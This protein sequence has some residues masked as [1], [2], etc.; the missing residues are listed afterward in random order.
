MTGITSANYF[1]EVASVNF[2]ALPAPLQKGHD[3]VVRATDGGRSW[4]MFNTSESIR[5][6]SELYFQQLTT[7]LAAQTKL[8]TAKPVKSKAVKSKKASSGKAKPPR[9]EKAPAKEKKVSTSSQLKHIHEDVKIIKRY[10]GLHNRV[11]T[12]N[13]ILN[14]IKALQKAIVQGFIT[15]DAKHASEIRYIQDKLVSLY[16]RMKEEQLILINDEDL[17]RLI[18]IAG[19]E[20]VFVSVGII[21]RFIGM[22][23][24]AVD[25]KRTGNL[26]KFIENGQ[27]KNKLNDDP[28]E[29]KVADI[30]KLLKKHNS[31]KQIKVAQAELNG[32]KKIVKTCGC[33][34]SVPDMKFHNNARA[35]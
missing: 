1:Q 31:T 13:A 10:V 7:Y 4:D 32:F 22:Q 11:K 28:Y 9:K 27:K 8:P 6:T 3:F 14:L 5:K 23:G 34:P 29:S 24:K 17:G 33:S 18:N 12:P 16:E 2:S 26:I 30:L 21:K 19:G 20:E 15:K 25:T 35:A